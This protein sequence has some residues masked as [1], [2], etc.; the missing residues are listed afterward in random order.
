MFLAVIDIVQGAGPLFWP[1]LLCSLVMIFVI[2]ERSYAL[3]QAAVMP[4]DLVDAVV[5]GKPITGGRHSTLAR[6]I[7]FAERHSEDPGAVKAFARLEVNRMERGIPYLDVIYA[8]A[9]MI[10][11]TGTVWSLLRVFSAISSETGLPDPVKFTSGVALALSATL[12]GLCIA[13]PSLVGGGYLN[14]RVGNYAAQL[15][16]L[17][18]RILARS[19]T[20][21][22][23]EVEV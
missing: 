21:N 15:D 6:I 12:L 3:R 13:I 18:E 1:L 14:R 2:C 23:V 19:R 9:P 11:L 16:V 7:E 20:K 17:L 10:G 5:T 8:A 4:P 22:A